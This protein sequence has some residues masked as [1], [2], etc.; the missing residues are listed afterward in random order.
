MSAN[1]AEAA[2]EL[3]GMDDDNQADKIALKAHRRVLL[4]PRSLVVCGVC[5]A[6]A[7]LVADV[8]CHRLAI[9][10]WHREVIMFSMIG[11]GQ[12]FYLRVH[13]KAIRS[14]ISRILH[15]LESHCIGCGHNLQGITS[16][17]CPE[18]G[19][20]FEAKLL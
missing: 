5:G 13:R 16:G 15:A 2:M 20:E 17:R 10:G 7:Y 4:R 1:Q 9:T 6:A 3:F 8:L 18:C 14:E 19:R 12:L 11:I